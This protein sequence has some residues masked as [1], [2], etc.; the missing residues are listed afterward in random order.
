MM[1]YFTDFMACFNDFL[2]VRACSN[3]LG[4]GFLEVGD[5]DPRATVVANE[6]SAPATVVPS[7]QKP[8]MLETEATLATGV[9]FP[10]RFQCSREEMRVW[11]AGKPSEYHLCRTRIDGL[12]PL[13]ATGLSV[14][15]EV[16]LPKAGFE[17]K[18]EGGGGG[19]FMTVIKI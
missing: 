5:V 4:L 1:R 14:S 17:T 3:H 9:R 6:G 10:F 19:L 11:V 2:A 15:R 8:K 13:G 18:P 12:D 16:E 7:K